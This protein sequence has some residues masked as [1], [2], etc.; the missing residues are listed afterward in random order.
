MFENRC[1]NCCHIQYDSCC[2]GYCNCKASQ[3]FQRVVV[4][5]AGCHVKQCTDFIYCPSYYGY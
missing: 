3:N 4:S 5:D 1:E 2:N